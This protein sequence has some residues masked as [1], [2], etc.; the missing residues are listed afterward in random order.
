VVEIEAGGTLMLNVV[1]LPPDPDTLPD[2]AK[3]NLQVLSRIIS[4]EE[5]YE[6]KI[7]SKLSGNALYEQHE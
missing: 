7:K 1:F 6:K 2:T 4:Y 3:R 5:E